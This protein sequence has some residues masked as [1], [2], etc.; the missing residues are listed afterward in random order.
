MTAKTTVCNEDT[1]RQEISL[2]HTAE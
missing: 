1:E 2:T